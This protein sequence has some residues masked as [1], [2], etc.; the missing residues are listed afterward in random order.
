M[1][2]LKNK[3]ILLGVSGGI[4]AYKAVE[5]LRL[6]VREGANVRV[7]MTESAKKF[8]T[9]L[10]FEAL[11]SNPVY[12]EV[13]G[14]ET[15]A[16]M[17][18]IRSAEGADL[19]VIAPATA[20]ILGRMAQGLADDALSMVYL[21][22]CGPVVVAPAMNDK[23][24]SHPAVRENVRVLRQRG[25]RFV[26]PE[27]GELACGTVGQ[28][29]LAEP[30]RILQ[31]AED[32]LRVEKDLD[33]KRILIT[34]G[35]TREP[36]DPVRFI[37]N[38]SSG[39]T[40]YAIAERAQ[41]RGAC[42]T[43]ISGPT[44]LPKPE[45]VTFVACERAEEMLQRVLEHFPACDV[46][47]MTAAVGDYAPESVAREKIKKQGGDPLV[48]KLRQTPDILQAIAE[49]KKRQMVVGFAAETQD[50]LAGAED[51]LRRKRLD[52]IVANNVATPGVGFQS[53]TNQVSILQSGRE[54][55]HL[56]LL[57]KHRIA[58]ILLDRIHALFHAQAT[59]R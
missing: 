31:A 7:V 13:F 56:P 10:T 34:A 3:K 40:G 17:E 36:L 46:L 2:S 59:E 39:K 53:D 6:L 4:S 32:V 45:G 52:L 43:L 57:S 35:P 37:S 18:H 24:Y 5:V 49:I 47:V 54:T 12:H 26:D 9:P 30:I 28:G 25:V 38:P 1:A 11:S 21:A 58:D 14:A 16:S 51:K 15:S 44:H 22:Y 20:N 55:E 42:V 19:L 48:L 27:V 29:R 50:V 23:M 41:Q 33:G 8:I